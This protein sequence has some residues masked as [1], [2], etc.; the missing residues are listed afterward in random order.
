MINM[1]AQ[2]LLYRSASKQA[3][4][5]PYTTYETVILNKAKNLLD[6]IGQ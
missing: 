1:M 2:G 5:F 4:S 3:L 6:F